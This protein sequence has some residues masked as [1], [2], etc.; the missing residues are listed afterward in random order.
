MRSNRILS[1]LHGGVLALA[2]IT[3][4]NNGSE[5]QTDMAKLPPPSQEVIDAAKARPAPTAR[6]KFG[7]LPRSE[8]PK[9]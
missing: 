8:M 9:P 4:C 3:G 5:G 1:G 7:S 6:P 2:T